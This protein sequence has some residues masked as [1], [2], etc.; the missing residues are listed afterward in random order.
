MSPLAVAYIW[1]FLLDARGP[2]N[3]VLR[4]AGLGDWTRT[5][6]GDPV[7]AIWGV[8]LVMVWQFA[9]LCM[10]FY[11]A[12]LQG[13][14]DDLHEAAAIDGAK[15]WRTFRK[16]V[17]PLLAPAATVSISITTI[18]GLRAFDQ[19]MALTRGG[20][21]AMSETLATQIFKQTFVFGNFGYGS[22]FALVLTLLILIVSA[23][24]IVVLRA[25]ERKVE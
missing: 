18:L 16:I 10:A 5:W 1:Q 13:I 15:P 11:L 19:I 23:I 24:Q 14:S 12:G 6:L 3:T 22:A 25:R 8:W 2:L 9:G 4:S 20:P 17:F 21:G 7:F